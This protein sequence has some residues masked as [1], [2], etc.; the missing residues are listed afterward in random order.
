M[1]RT[2][3][4][5][6]SGLDPRCFVGGHSFIRRLITHWTR[7]NNFDMPFRGEAR[8]QGNMTIQELYDYLKKRNMSRFQ[9]VVLQIGENDI[10][11]LTVGQIIT[12]MI[13]LYEY[14]KRQGVDS[15]RFGEIFPRHH[16]KLNKKIHK[17][18]TI[19]ARKHP[20]MFWSHGG[21]ASKDAIS[22]K[23]HIHIRDDL[24]YLFQDSI[25]RALSQQ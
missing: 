1:V 7:G 9:L 14:L 22:Q 18:N 2:E 3:R 8:G 21:L 10:E 11:T 24:Q 20:H 4:Y 25:A 23:D 12:N 17:L 19:L 15:V 5:V 16:R 13:L 6:W